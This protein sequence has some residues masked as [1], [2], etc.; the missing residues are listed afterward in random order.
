MHLRFAFLATATAIV[1][2]ACGAAGPTATGP[3]AIG[4]TAGAPSAG[5]PI[6][7][8]IDDRAITLTSDHG[9][10]TVRLELHNIGTT[11]CDLVIVLTSLPAGALPV[12]DGRVDVPEDG[13]GPVRNM[14]GGEFPDELQPGAAQ[15][16]DLG[17]E[18]IPATDDRVVLCNGVG[19]YKA[20]RFAFLRFDR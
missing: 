11:P 12:K 1:V 6:T 20:G 9:G 18:S 19:D 2:V 15:T 17:L 4:P 13:S 7:G 3:T 10:Q 8:K 5:G 16:V 14:S